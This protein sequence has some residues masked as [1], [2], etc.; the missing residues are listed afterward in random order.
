MTSYKTDRLFQLVINLNFQCQTANQSA[1]ANKFETLTD[2]WYIR[3][4]WEA[5]SEANCGASG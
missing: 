1:N 3:K 2:D 5:L 4:N